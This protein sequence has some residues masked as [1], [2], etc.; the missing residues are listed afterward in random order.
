MRKILCVLM[1]G[2]IT[3]GFSQLNFEAPWVKGSDITV[4]GKINFN[5][6]V[7]AGNTYWKNR[8]KN[9]K[10]SGY[11][12][13]KRWE[14]YWQNYVDQEGF[15][16]S[17]AELWNSWV[18]K[19]SRTQ[20][21]TTNQG[22]TDQSN[23][24]SLG[25]TDFLNRPTSYLNLGRVNCVTPHP[26]NTDIVYVGTPSGGIWKSVDGGLTYA[27]LSDDL[28]QIG[29]SSI[30]IDY[31]NP[32]TIYIATGDDDAGDSYSVGIWKSTNS[33]ATWNQTDLNPNNSDIFDSNMYVYKRNPDG[34][35][36]NEQNEVVTSVTQAV[37][38][39]HPEFQFKVEIKKP[40]YE[41]VDL[42]TL[43]NKFDI[44]FDNESIDN[45]LLSNN[46]DPD[47]Y[48]KYKNYYDE[49]IKN[50]DTWEEK[51]TKNIMRSIGCHR[52]RNDKNKIGYWG[53]DETSNIWK[54]LEKDKPGNF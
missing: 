27:P 7:T 15:L 52:L 44:P 46:F 32:S 21:R 33:G 30:A 17:T 37:I 51:T 49:Y 13:F 54:C 16:P 8:D 29:V 39:R 36:V 47:K 34:N 42:Y 22:L 53:Y 3:V 5:A 23:W 24:I 50:K 10:G 45:S 12:P 9:A 40:V 38:K 14:A 43:I 35:L 20:F 28:P 19:N 1:F 48:E 26:T 2:C 41:I 11:K 31:N 4:N 25:P 18:E 6:V